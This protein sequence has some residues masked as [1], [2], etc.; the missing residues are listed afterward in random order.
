MMKAR[1]LWGRLVCAFLV[2]TQVYAYVDYY[3]YDD[4]DLDFLSETSAS[5]AA[6]PSNDAVH[7]LAA[8]LAAEPI[9]PDARHKLMHLYESADPDT[10]VII[11]ASV[12]MG[13]LEPLARCSACEAAVGELQMALLDVIKSGS[14]ANRK[15][16]I[17]WTQAWR[18][19]PGHEKAELLEAL[20]TPDLCS[21]RL[22][23][24]GVHQ[25]SRMFLPAHFGGRVVPGVESD[26]DALDLLVKQ[27]KYMEFAMKPQVVAKLATDEERIDRQIV[28][29][30]GKL[31]TQLPALWHS[32]RKE[33]CNKL[34]R[35]DGACL[36]QEH[37]L[38]TRK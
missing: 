4:N 18:D 31:E 15:P 23:H 38:F 5:Y 9:T 35:A 30:G 10:K 16:R 26:P 33:M 3:N 12:E 22:Q 6:A 7:N 14:V 37:P 8:L 28:Q 29:K 13:K 24:Y 17:H 36:S 32:L 27:C 1:S 25:T 2:S 21:N 34:S 11:Q 20:F 19:L